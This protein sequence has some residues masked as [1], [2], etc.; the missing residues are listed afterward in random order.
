MV[1]RKDFFRVG[2]SVPLVRFRTSREP[3]YPFLYTKTRAVPALASSSLLRKHLNGSEEPSSFSDGLMRFSDGRLRFSD[4]RFRLPV[5][6][7][8]FF[9]GL[10]HTLERR[11]IFEMG[12]SVF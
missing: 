7:M 11:W 8:Q 1:E 3:R 6:L 5:G 2:T 4:G 12:H 10:M 9:F